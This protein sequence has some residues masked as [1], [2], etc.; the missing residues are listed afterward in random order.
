MR[1]HQ[2]RG[3]RGVFAILG[4]NRCTQGM[5]TCFGV[6]SVLISASLCNKDG[7]QHTIGIHQIAVGIKKLIYAILAL[8]IVF[9]AVLHAVHRV[10]IHKGVNG[11]QLRNDNKGD[12]QDNC[13]RRKCNNGNFLA[14]YHRALFILLRCGFFPTGNQ[15]NVLIRFN[16]RIGGNKHVTVIPTAKG[17]P[18]ASGRWKCTK[19]LSNNTLSAQL[20]DVTSVGIKY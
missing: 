15:T 18:A 3:T 16:E 20:R 6:Y 7:C 4:V 11:D 17:V 12:D 5:C 1:E 14:L 13:N 10:V 8:D 2:K 9:V 19:R